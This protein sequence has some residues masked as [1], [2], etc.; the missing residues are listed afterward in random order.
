MTRPGARLRSVA[1]RFFDP[2]TMERLIDPAIADLQHEHSDA[3]RRGLVGCIAVWKVIAASATTA[4]TRAIGDWAC[5]DGCAL[6][7]TICYS[8]A[9]IAAVVALL[10]W[11]ALSTYFHRMPANKLAWM[12]IYLVPHTL[13]LAIPLGLMFGVL[14]GLRG[15]VATARV[16]RSVAAMTIVCSIA[17]FVLARQAGYAA[18]QQANVAVAWIPN[19]VFL[20]MTLLLLRRRPFVTETQQSHQ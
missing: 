19:L 13:L 10:I 15:S 1:T 9:T 3:I 4:S 12:V 17:T 11:P 18:D 8:L 20:A 7:R 16:R 2:S 5:A 14:S 6:W